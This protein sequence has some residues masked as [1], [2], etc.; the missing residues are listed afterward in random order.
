MKGITPVIAIILLLL[1]SV[2]AAGGFYFVYQNFSETG[3]ESGSSQ[4]ENLGESTLAAI[5]IESAAGGKIYVRN[6]GSTTI[7]ASRLSVYVDGVAIDVNASTE[8]LEENSRASLKL[9]KAPTCASTKCEIKISGPASITKIIDYNK[10]I[11]S[12]NSE[13]AFNERCLNYVCRDSLNNIFFGS[14]FP[15]PRIKYFD[16]NDRTLVNASDIFDTSFSIA[17]SAYDFDGDSFDEILY[18]TQESAG[19]GY[20]EWGWINGT[21]GSWTNNTIFRSKDVP[22]VIVPMIGDVDGDGEI[23]VVTTSLSGVANISVWEWTGAGFTETRINQT[24]AVAFNGC[25]NS[26]IADFDRDGVDEIMCVMKFSQAP[27]YILRFDY[28]DGS[29]VKTQVNTTL[30]SEAIVASGDTD[31][32]GYLELIV[33]D[34]GGQTLAGD[35][36]AKGSIMK[37]EYGESSWEELEYVGKGTDGSGNLVNVGDIDND[38]IGEIVV[39]AEDTGLFVFD[40]DG[41]EYIK[42]EL[43]ETPLV[44]MISSN[45]HDYDRDGLNEIIAITADFDTG[46]GEI[47]GYKYADGAWDEEVLIASGAGGVF[48]GMGDV[49]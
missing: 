48:C 39:G 34:N 26:A 7:D 14:F 12:S 18:G 5:K 27:G 21:V 30:T 9:T 20:T 6:T 43:N 28:V 42:T 35:E 32:D 3:Q 36:W 17:I 45:I 47:R 4:I 1:M 19:L 37:Y 23:E 29:Y 22:G 38:R 13:C 41:S 10:L 8:N 33:G 15:Y 44:G 2:A 46:E 16:Y 24:T 25:D 49:V 11:C 40:W 31:G